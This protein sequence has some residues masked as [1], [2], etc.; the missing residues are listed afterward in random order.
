MRPEIEVSV[1]CLVKT[2]ADDAGLRH[3][4]HKLDDHVQLIS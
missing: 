3:A 2:H 4:I 1:I